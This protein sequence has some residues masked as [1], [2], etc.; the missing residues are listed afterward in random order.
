MDYT[1]QTQQ[2]LIDKLCENNLYINLSD[3]EK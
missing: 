1:E 2:D 3:D